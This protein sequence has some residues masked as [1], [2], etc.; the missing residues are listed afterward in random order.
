MNIEIY[1][2]QIKSE[3]EF[4]NEIARQLN[5]EN[6]YGKNLDALWEL[7]SI[8]VERPIN[9]VWIDANTSRNRISSFETI[10]SVLE[11]VKEQDEQ[12]EW[13]D[14]FTFTLIP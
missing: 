9:L 5:V 1:G 13:E 14:K 10:I 3:L 7:L 11:R 2:N 4:H 12:F 6:Y 8:G